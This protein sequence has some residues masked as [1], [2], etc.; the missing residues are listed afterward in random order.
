MNKKKVAQE[1]EN[2][3]WETIKGES[4]PDSFEWEVT[5]SYKGKRITLDN[6]T[7]N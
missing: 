4:D 5:F 7:L 2:A 6:D 1:I 3:I